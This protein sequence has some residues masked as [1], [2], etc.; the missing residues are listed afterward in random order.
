MGILYFISGNRDNEYLK[1][2][3]KLCEYNKSF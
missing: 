3:T 1:D 2:L